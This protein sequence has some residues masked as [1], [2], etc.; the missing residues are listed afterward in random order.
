MGNCRP[1]KRSAWRMRHPTSS[2]RSCQA[3]TF[4]GRHEE[5][6]DQV[7]IPN[8]R[9]AR[10]MSQST[11]RQFA[12]TCGCRTEISKD[13]TTSTS[14]RKS[15]LL[16]RSCRLWTSLC[17]LCLTPTFCQTTTVVVRGLGRVFLCLVCLFL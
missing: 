3:E 10:R 16:L 1:N 5:P 17:V 14:Q 4:R 13:L 7:R 8:Q 15:E 9:S 6:T 11:S 12:C 2:W